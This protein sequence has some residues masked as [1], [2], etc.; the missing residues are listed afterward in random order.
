[1][2]NLTQNLTLFGVSYMVLIFLST[3]AM[4]CHVSG[5]GPRERS[6]ERCVDRPGV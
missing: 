3:S 6:E 2:Q 1:M 5:T 4:P